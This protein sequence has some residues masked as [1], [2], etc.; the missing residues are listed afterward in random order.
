MCSRSLSWL[1]P[2]MLVKSCS[3]AGSRLEM[4]GAYSGQ[5]EQ[6]KAEGDSKTETERRCPVLKPN[7]LPP[8]RQS[9]AAPPRWLETKLIGCR[10]DDVIGCPDRASLRCLGTKITNVMGNSFRDDPKGNAP[11]ARQLS[12]HEL[13]TSVKRMGTCGLGFSV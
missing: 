2:R 5:H 9:F 11:D 10:G 4:A 7:H 12:F 8:W 1:E 13:G 3:G 6:A